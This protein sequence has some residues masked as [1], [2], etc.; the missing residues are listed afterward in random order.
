[1]LA[2]HVTLSLLPVFV[3]MVCAFITGFLFRS[4][5]LKALR[6]KVLGLEKEMLSNHADILD[7]EKGKAILLKQ[8]KESRIPVIPMNSTKEDGDK[9]ENR[10]AK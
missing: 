8:M 10:H 5:Q 3:L 4:G 9:H 6:K 1:M 7:L 2:I